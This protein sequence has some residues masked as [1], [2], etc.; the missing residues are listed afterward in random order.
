M[1]GYGSRILGCSA[2]NKHWLAAS[3]ATSG[4][5]VALPVVGLP[6]G[7]LALQAGNQELLM[8]P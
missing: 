3:Y 7:D 2:L 8:R 5:D 6:G 1:P 4:A